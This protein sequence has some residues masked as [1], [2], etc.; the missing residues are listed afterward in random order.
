[1]YCE[2]CKVE[3]DETL[4]Y[5]KWCGQALLDSP[6][7][8]QAQTCPA[9]RAMVQAG[10]TYCTVC[11]YKLTLDTS[12]TQVMG[13]V[14]V[15]KSEPN[16]NTSHQSTSHQSDAQRC[17][18]CGESLEPGTAYCKAC[19]TPIYLEFNPSAPAYTQPVTPA[20]QMPA[21]PR[22]RFDSS[23]LPDLGTRMQNQESNLENN[24]ENKGTVE[25]A[26]GFVPSGLEHTDSGLIFSPSG[27][28]QVVEET[29][30]LPADSATDRAAQQ[31]L[32]LDTEETGSQTIQISSDVLQ[33][34]SIAVESENITSPENITSH[35]ESDTL[36]VEAQTSY[37][38]SETTG[39]ESST[40]QVES[41]TVPIRSRRSRGDTG[42]LTEDD[43]NEQQRPVV[44]L[45]KGRPTSVL[46]G[47]PV[48]EM[49]AE[50]PIVE[51]PIVETPPV[52]TPPAAQSPAAQSP[53]ADLFDFSEVHA[54][55]QETVK[56]A[57]PGGTAEFASPSSGQNQTAEDGRTLVIASEPFV[58]DI[59]EQKKDTPPPTQEMPQIRPTAPVGPAPPPSPS[60]P[61]TG[62]QPAIT[63]RPNAASGLNDA[64]RNAFGMGEK[65]NIP[66]PAPRDYPAQMVYSPEAMAAQIMPPP[67]TAPRKSHLPILSII[68]AV[69]LIGAAG[70]AVWYYS[71]TIA[72]NTPAPI[73]VTVTEPTQPTP[74]SQPETKTTPTPPAGMAF[75]PGGTYSVG[76]DT[77]DELAR[78]AHS[79][80]I[81]P[82]F[83]DVTE[84][85]NADYKAFLDATGRRGPEGWEGSSYQAGRGNWPVTGVTW[86]EAADYAQW[87]GKRLPTEA[88]WEAAARGQEGNLYPWGNV[89]GEGMANIRTSSIT[90]V[91]RFKEGASPFGLLD[92]IG[93]VWEWTADGFSL[94]PGSPADITDLLEPGVTYRI[95]R[96]GA[97]NRRENTEASYRGFLDASKGYPQTGFRCA[98]DAK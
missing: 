85:T 76:T 18:A 96:G 7:P 67:A 75:V 8:V 11:G 3:F 54:V 64:A 35:I 66:P 24:L 23:A 59:E 20:P 6:Q 81:A 41:D 30:A 37:I 13:S 83:I 80:P 50:T 92:M 90:E 43:L 28:E 65:V 57:A 38:E 77:G 60:I 87:A 5:C 79:V 95:I 88:E 68:I 45:D 71:A 29:T 46:Q 31:T 33:I 34:G 52:A 42:K 72:R 21:S 93:N 51:T 97:H 1:M 16:Q 73:D 61:I 22:T 44:S 74:P 78:P 86:Q 39:I 56:Q 70:L 48:E 62:T 25:M 32:K 91:G 19:G 17:T 9:C 89:W 27:T 4:R 69:T 14:K 84:V 58:F 15:E 10:L 94:Y 40:L 49:T 36:Q 26:S 63:D 98:K 53:T 82:Y 55:E 2:A 47:L 12:G